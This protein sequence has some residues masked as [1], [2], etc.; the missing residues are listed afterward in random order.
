MPSIQGQEICQL[1]CLPITLNLDMSSN[2]IILGQSFLDATSAYASRIVSFLL[3]FCLQGHGR[4]TGRELSERLEVS[5]R[6][7]HRDMEA[8]SSAGVPCPLRFAAL[9][10]AGS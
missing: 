8:L 3:C 10:A 5:E 6:T 9:V 7:L 4:L 2:V 1:S